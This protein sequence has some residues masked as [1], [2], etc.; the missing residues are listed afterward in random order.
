MKAM[1]SCNTSINNR[2]NNSNN[3]KQGQIANKSHSAGIIATLAAII[4]IE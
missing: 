4:A 2:P 3:N 1:P